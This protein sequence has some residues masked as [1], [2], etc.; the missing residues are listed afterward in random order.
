[1]AE[2]PATNRGKRLTIS[3]FDPGDGPEG[4]YILDFVGP[5]NAGL[6]GANVNDP[7]TGTTIGELAPSCSYSARGNSPSAASPCSITTRDAGGAIYNGLWLDV[8]ITL[9][10][11]YN[12]STDCWWKIRYRFTG[13]SLPL[14]GDPP[15][16]PTD[17]T[18]YVVRVSGDPVRVIA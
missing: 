11:A 13:L 16:T 3:L 9:P 10:A 2:I 7:C 8:S 6:S 1:L 14:P 4:T 15:A 12:C 17:R 18:T 5:D